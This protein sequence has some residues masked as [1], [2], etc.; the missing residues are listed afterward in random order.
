MEYDYLAM[1]YTRVVHI[2]VTKVML[3]RVNYIGGGILV[4]IT[5]FLQYNTHFFNNFTPSQSRN[6]LN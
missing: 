1:Y 5:I 6:W 2:V 3:Y 4:N